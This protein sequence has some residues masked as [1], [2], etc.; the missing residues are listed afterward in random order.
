MGLDERFSNRAFP[1]ALR[2]NYGL[3]DLLCEKF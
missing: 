3:L 2:S 1:L